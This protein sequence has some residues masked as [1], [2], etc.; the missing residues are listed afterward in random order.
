MILEPMTLKL[1]RLHN[2]EIGYIDE[3]LSGSHRRRYRVN[4]VPEARSTEGTPQASRIF[5][6]PDGWRRGS[7][8]WNPQL[9]RL[10]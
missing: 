8:S 5:S 3:N 10:G 7:S 1:S 6:F 9:N 4:H 2:W